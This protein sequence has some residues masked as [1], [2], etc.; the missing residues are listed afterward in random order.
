VKE[1]V[2]CCLA[3]CYELNVEIGVLSIGINVGNFFT[4]VDSLSLGRTFGGQRLL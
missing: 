4:D 3:A 2:R 1:G